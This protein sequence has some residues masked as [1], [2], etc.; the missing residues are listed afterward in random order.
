MNLHSLRTVTDYQ[1]VPEITKIEMHVD[2]TTLTYVGDK[3]DH[4]VIFYKLH[5][6]KF[7]TGSQGIE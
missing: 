7:K 6:R 5:C 1:T 2:D 4:V 3:V